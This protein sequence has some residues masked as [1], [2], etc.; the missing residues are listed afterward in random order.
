[1]ASLTLEPIAAINMAIPEKFRLLNIA[2]VDVGAGTSDISIVKDGSIIAFGMI[3]LAGDEVTEAIAK[4]YLTDF[5]TAE[6][7]KRACERKKSVSFKDI[8]G[9]KIQVTKEDIAQIS[10]DA[11]KNITKNI[12]DRI[13]ELD[14]KSVV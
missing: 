14:R 6:Y 2:L 9:S 12:A 11:V 1:M 13:L 5:E 8:F 7:I 10:E 3:P 4:K